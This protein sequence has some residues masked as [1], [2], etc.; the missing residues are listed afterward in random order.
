[1]PGTSQDPED[2]PHGAPRILSGF[3]I[4]F[5]IDALG[6]FW[7]L[8]QGRNTVGREGAVQGLDVPIAHPTTSSRHAVVLAAAR[9]GRLK[10]E[11]SGSTNGTFV[12]DARLAP[13]QRIELRDG[14]RIRFGLFSAMVK[15]V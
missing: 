10:I 3:V 1:M 4:S 2:V 13:G 11:D 15:I 14:D 6:R 9:P 8:Y 12:N 5:D 7:P